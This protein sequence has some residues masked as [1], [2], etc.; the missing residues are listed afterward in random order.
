MIR[1][2]MQCMQGVFLKSG[3]ERRLHML[4]RGGIK[5]DRSSCPG[6]GG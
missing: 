6:R 4:S 1:P 2:E 3:L 5:T